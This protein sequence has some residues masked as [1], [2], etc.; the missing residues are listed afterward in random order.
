MVLF[1]RGIISISQD[2]DGRLWDD[3]GLRMRAYLRVFDLSVFET[4][5]VR[6]EDTMV[7]PMYDI[8]ISIH[9]IPITTAEL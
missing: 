8:T 3:R 9:T 5:S 2:G 6:Y 4:G 7:R 1:R